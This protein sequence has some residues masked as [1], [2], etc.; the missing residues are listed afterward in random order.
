MA[1]N[2]GGYPE[3]FEQ[4]WVRCGKPT[5]AKCPHG[6][7]W[8]A[9]WTEGKKTRKRYVG[10]KDP[11]GAA[12]SAPPPG[13]SAPDR[14]AWEREERERREREAAEGRARFERERRAREDRQ[15]AEDEERRRAE[16]AARARRAR[17]PATDRDDAATLGVEDPASLTQ[18]ALKKAY[19]R[20]SLKA[21]PDHG[22]SNDAMK[23]VN[24]AYERMLRRR[25]WTR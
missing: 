13:G 25:G 18:E 23:A 3:T 2:L 24:L 6:P 1:K 10:K 14:E 11:R 20:A 9:Y 22:G 17:P 16:D 19:R 5:C 15:R 7:Y 8:Y 4:E 12:S 21:H